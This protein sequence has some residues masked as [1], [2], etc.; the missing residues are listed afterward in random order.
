MSCFHWIKPEWTA[1]FDK[2]HHSRD[3]FLARYV[4]LTYST[5]SR[6]SYSARY[7]CEQPLVSYNS[8]QVKCYTTNGIST[9]KKFTLSNCCLRCTLYF[10]YAQFGNKRERGFRFYPMQRS[11][12]FC[13]S[14][15][16]YTQRITI[17]IEF[18][19]CLAC[20]SLK[21]FAWFAYTSS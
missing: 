8:C 17:A 1:W 13:W 18:Q 15:R 21:H 10:N 11:L 7:D 14:I 16:V 12:N 3:A 6:S 19:C 20:F 4:C 9:G 5:N 2:I